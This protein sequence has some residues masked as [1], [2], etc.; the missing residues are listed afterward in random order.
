MMNQINYICMCVYGKND[1]I[2]IINIKSFLLYTYICS[3]FDSSLDVNRHWVECHGWGTD[4]WAGS[5]LVDEIFIVY[6]NYKSFIFEI[7]WS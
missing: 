5:R 4:R 7:F 1:L 6:H 2:L 3:L